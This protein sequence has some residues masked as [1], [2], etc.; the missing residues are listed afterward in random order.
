MRCNAFRLIVWIRLRKF[1]P[2]FLYFVIERKL[3]K[4][5]SVEISRSATIGERLRIAHIPGIVIGDGVRIG[6]DCILFQGVLI[7]QTHGKYPTL[8]NNITL[9]ANACVLGD[10]Q[11]GDN[12]IVL[13]NSV[14][15][16]NI[17]ANSIVA[18]APARVIKERGSLKV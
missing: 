1:F 8:G 9:C 3:L 7:G 2:K 13:A 6:H 12:V 15:T 16:H 4:D 11:I 17:P 14:V 10:V 5:F 18:G